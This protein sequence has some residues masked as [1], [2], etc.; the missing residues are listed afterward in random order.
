ML[1]NVDNFVRAE[2]ALQFDRIL[3]GARGV[4]R[5]GHLR[6]PTPVEQQDVIRMNRDTV[7]SFAVVDISSG[8]TV[9]LPDASGRYLSVMVVNEDHYLNR[10]LHD[11]GEHSLSVDEFDTGWVV[12]AGRILADPNDEV[13]LAEVHRLQDALIIDAG[14]RRPWRHE[15]YDDDTLTKT[16]DL[17]LGL[18][19][20]V[21]DSKRTFGA[22]EDVDPVRHLLGT[23]AGWGGM[24]ETEAV[25]EMYGEP[26]P[27]GTY[28]VTVRDVPVDSF[29]SISIYNR[30]GYFEPN[31]Y[32][33]Y[34][35][36]SVTAEP[37]ADGSITISFAPEPTGHPNYLHVMDGWNYTVRY[38][39]PQQ[40]ILDGTWTFPVPT[41]V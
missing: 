32:E 21:G 5:W 29:W 16:R 30:D 8:A 27:A 37:A 39:L 34:S 1:V 19:A 11:P 35:L 20:G 31:P 7:Y 2:T 14:S 22:K 41:Q 17:V 36:N 24:P 38:Y 18:A 15:S 25:Y 10:I 28:E 12:L 9:T 13:D 33:S 4:N 40:P 6:E 26:R 23:A 3:R